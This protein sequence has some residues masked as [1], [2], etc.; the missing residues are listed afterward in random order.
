MNVDGRNEYIYRKKK[1]Y[2]GKIKPRKQINH[3]DCK[4]L[5]LGINGEW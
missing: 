3:A 1:L 4:Q 5:Y 2:I